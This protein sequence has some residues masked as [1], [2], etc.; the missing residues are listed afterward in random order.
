MFRYEMLDKAEICDIQTAVD[1]PWQ[2]RPSGFLQQ[3]HVILESRREKGGRLGDGEGANPDCTIL[4]LKGCGI[5][6]S[7]YSFLC[8]LRPVASP[9][10]NYLM[11]EEALK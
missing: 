5:L 2:L 1:S 9:R 7:R 11:V 10:A 3:L 8:S 6:R 4:F